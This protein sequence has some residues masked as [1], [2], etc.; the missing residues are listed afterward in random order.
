MNTE[1]LLRFAGED[2]KIFSED[3][4]DRNNDEIFEMSTK[5]L[6]RHWLTFFEVTSN[7]I[8]YADDVVAEY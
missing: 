3:S 2:Y 1:L 5:N 4:A 6:Q 7:L 8:K